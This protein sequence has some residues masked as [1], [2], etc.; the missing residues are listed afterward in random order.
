M[1]HVVLES[2]EGPSSD[3]LPSRLVI[4]VQ[5]SPQDPE[6]RHTH[7]CLCMATQPDQSGRDVG[8]EVGV[9]LVLAAICNEDAQTP[10][11]VSHRLMEGSQSQH[12]HKCWYRMLHLFN[13]WWILLVLDEIGQCPTDITSK[14]I[15][16]VFVLDEKS[17]DPLN[18]AILE[19]VLSDL[20]HISLYVSDEPDGCL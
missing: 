14:G 1:I 4:T 16:G 20:W 2:L 15:V 3:H 9:D 17:R 7:L 5:Q 13:C 18:Q 8:L 10:H 11:D 19:D 12:V 6:T